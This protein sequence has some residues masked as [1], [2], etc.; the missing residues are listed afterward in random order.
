ML[1]TPST[2]GNEVRNVTFWMPNTE[3]PAPESV[4]SNWPPEGNE[5]KRVN[6]TCIE[7]EDELRWFTLEQVA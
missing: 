1:A 4:K 2:P 3:S 5:L 7:R 6:E